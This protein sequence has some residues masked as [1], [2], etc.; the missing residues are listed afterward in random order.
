[1]PRPPADVP[2]TAIKIKGVEPG[3][4]ATPALFVAVARTMLAERSKVRDSSAARQVP[5]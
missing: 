5:C 1:M 3:Y 4:R 2:H